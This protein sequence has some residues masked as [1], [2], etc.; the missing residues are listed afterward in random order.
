MNWKDK[1][2]VV[3][4]IAF[5]IFIIYALVQIMLTPDPD[6]L[7]NWLFILEMFSAFMY[8]FLKV[9]HVFLKKSNKAASDKLD[10]IS[11]WFL[12]ILVALA[13]TIRILRH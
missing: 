9:V 12:F 11:G 7:I 2:K 6:N 8:M 1:T 3:I 4:G 5:L 10:D 13:I